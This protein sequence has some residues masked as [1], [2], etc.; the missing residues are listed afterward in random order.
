MRDSHKQQGEL[1]TH[2]GKPGDGGAHT[3]GG[4]EAHGGELFWFLNTPSCYNELNNSC[5]RWVFYCDLVTLLET[6]APTDTFF[7]F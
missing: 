2:E 7:L 4:P 6:N 1:F 5:D 3:Y